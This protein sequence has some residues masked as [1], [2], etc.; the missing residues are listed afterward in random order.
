MNLEFD[1]LNIEERPTIVLETMDFSPIAVMGDAYELTA[2]IAYNEVSEIQFK[3][4]QFVDGIENT[5][6]DEIKTMRIAHVTGLGRF[7]LASPQDTIDGIC[8][9]KVCKGY[10]LEYELTSKTL[11]LPSGTYNLWNPLN[12]YGT[13]LGM[14]MRDFPHWKVNHLVDGVITIKID[15]CLVNKYRTFE[16]SDNF[17]NFFKSTAQQ[18]Y[19]CIFEFDPFERI[20]SVR[21]AVEG[22]SQLPVYI[23]PENL[24]KE[25]QVEELSEQIFT[26]LDVN[27]ASGVDI[28]SV[29][30]TGTNKIYN[31]DYYMTED[32]FSPELIEKYHEWHQKI[33]DVRNSYYSY[34]IQRANAYVELELAKAE[35]KELQSEYISKENLYSTAAQYELKGGKPAP[36]SATYRTQMN[37]VKEKMLIK[38]AQINTIQTRIEALQKVLD[39]ASNG[40]AFESYFADELVQ[41]SPYL[42]E[43]V[44]TES[45]FVTMNTKTYGD[46]GALVTGYQFDVLIEDASVVDC[47][48]SGS[49]NG[50]LATDSSIV[51]YRADGGSVVINALSLKDDGTAVTTQI[52]GDVQHAVYNIDTKENRLVGSVVFQKEVTNEDG[53]TDT[54]T[55]TLTIARS[56]FTVDMLDV[57]TT[58]DYESESLEYDYTG[59]MKLS[60]LKDVTLYLTSETTEFQRS[61]VQWDLYDYAWELLNKS[62][63][64]SYSFNV[65][66]ANFLALDDFKMFKNWFKLGE[67]VYLQLREGYAITPVVVRAEFEYD[68]PESLNL[69]FANQFN[70]N[71]GEFN[72]VDLL[73]K[74]VSMGST[75]DTSKFSYNQFVETGASTALD[76][77]MH[78]EL[79]L[80][81]NAIKSSSGQ[82]IAIDGSGIHLRKL[83]TSDFDPNRT[84]EDGSP[85]YDD[86]TINSEYDPCQIWMNNDTI[87]FT[88]DGWQTCKMAIG[89]GSLG[90]G[91]IA[92]YLVGTFVA[93]KN[94]LVTNSSGTVTIDE[95]GLMVDGMNFVVKNTVDDTETRLME[96]LESSSSFAQAT[97]PESPG[98]GDLWY[99]DSD[100]DIVSGDVTYKHGKWY[101]FDGTIWV[102]LTDA[103]LSAILTT[104]QNGDPKVNLGSVQGVIN[105]TVSGMQNTIG[106]LYMDESGLWLLS[107]SA[108]PKTASKAIWINGAGILISNDRTASNSNCPSYNENTGKSF[109]WSTAISGDAVAAT[110][111][112][113]KSIFGEIELGIGAPKTAGVDSTRPFYVDSKGFLHA[114]DAEVKGDIYC[115]TLYVDDEDIMDL[116]RALS[117]NIEATEDELELSNTELDIKFTRSGNDITHEGGGITFTDMSNGGTRGNAGLLGADIA[118]SGTTGLG[119]ETK[120]G[121][122]IVMASGGDMAFDA[123]GGIYIGQNATD[124]CI[125]NNNTGVDL[126]SIGPSESFCSTAISGDNVSGWVY[127]NG[128]TIKD[129]LTEASAG[130]G[131]AVYA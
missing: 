100:T 50:I 10:S 97:V 22:A 117:R 118:A 61:N 122:P 60:A 32:N 27:G 47:T 25:I 16:V 48:N 63:Y 64:P 72:L 49:D 24:A 11:N 52:K 76:D 37:E 95:N 127:I 51:T 26:V 90:Y 70:S 12:P 35:L 81:L 96:L 46:S 28:R 1:K 34:T 120:S 20:I 38:E 126:I 74:S 80:A 88:D 6:Y 66:S 3:V 110:Q 71:S 57:K 125:G 62:A 111:F 85:M 109:T 89:S 54:I 114:N 17:L 107:G 82:D 121:Y 39:D 131:T 58:Y 98:E 56:N 29:N 112:V 19:Q 130:G 102:E 75:I 30:P 13:I 115:D 4:P 116:L 68:D 84:R 14:F 42:K 55:A 87:L 129:W 91:I 44:L 108:D 124:I 33:V 73:E 36:D 21:S 69:E 78:A 15:S 119:L 40:L 7:I 92:D 103:D 8:A 43:S 128:R 79:D 67:R 53:T 18:S 9:V 77:F 105:T 59:H 99:V 93:S 113:G 2:N 23:A 83:K 104:D 101:R 45:S 106:N 31:L 94:L 86:I 65:S 41:L 123:T 5:Y